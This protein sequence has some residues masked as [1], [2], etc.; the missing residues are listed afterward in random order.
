MLLSE[1]ERVVECIKLS[2]CLENKMY[3][4]P[5]F[6]PR[7]RSGEEIF[8]S[9]P[10]Y[11]NIGYYNSSSYSSKTLKITGEIA[12]ISAINNTNNNNNSNNN[13]NNTNNNSTD[14]ILN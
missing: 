10:L 8:L 11:S 12:S 5:W 3:C 7:F 6:L 14:T 9:K 13:N 4:T 1:V 2:I